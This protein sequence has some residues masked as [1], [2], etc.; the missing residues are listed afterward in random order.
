MFHFA[1]MLS[2]IHLEFPGRV[3]TLY[4]DCMLAQSDI[5]RYFLLVT[6]QKSRHPLRPNRKTIPKPIIDRKIENNLSHQKLNSK[7]ITLFDIPLTN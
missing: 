4:I 5:Y 3:L 7:S 6:V 2:D 1:E